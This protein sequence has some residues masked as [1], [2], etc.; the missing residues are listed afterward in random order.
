MIYPSD[1][2]FVFLRQYETIA[3]Y[4][5]LPVFHFLWHKQEGCRNN[6]KD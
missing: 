5:R 3:I 4:I 2:V 6:E 1:I